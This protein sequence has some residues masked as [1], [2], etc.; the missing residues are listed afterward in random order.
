MLLMRNLLVGPS[1]LSALLTALPDAYA[2]P[3]AYTISGNAN[4][5][6]GGGRAGN[7]PF[8]IRVIGDTADIVEGSAFKSLENFVTDVQVSG[9]EPATFTTDYRLLVD[10]VF[11]EH[12]GTHHRPLA[13]IQRCS[14]A[15][16]RAIS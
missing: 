8:T 12:V 10:H 4:I 14:D 1:I 15:Q 3:V 5:T 16:Q 13:R 2:V 9:F 6:F 11:H 7:T